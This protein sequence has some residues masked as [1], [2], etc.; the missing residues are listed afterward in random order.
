ML[1]HGYVV[2]WWVCDDGDSGWGVELCS[3][4]MF[5]RVFQIILILIMCFN[6]TVGPNNITLGC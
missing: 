6:I 1:K 2:E 3:L 5:F 4:Y